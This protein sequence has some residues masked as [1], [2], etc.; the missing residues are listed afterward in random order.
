M[1]FSWREP[2]HRRANLRLRGVTTRNA[3]G[4]A[5]DNDSLVARV[6]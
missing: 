3:L 6:P 5:T 4:F 1:T 2:T